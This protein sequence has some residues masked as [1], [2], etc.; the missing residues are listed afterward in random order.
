MFCGNAPRLF[1]MVTVQR[2]LNLQ[3]LSVPR[4]SYGLYDK[5]FWY[6]CRRIKRNFAGTQFPLT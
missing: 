3:L 5:V 1:Q 4:L 2:F 6:V